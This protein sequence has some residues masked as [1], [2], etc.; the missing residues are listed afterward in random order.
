VAQIAR[1]ITPPILK[2]PPDEPAVLGVALNE[3]FVPIL[4]SSSRK[5]SI[6]ICRRKGVHIALPS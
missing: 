5:S 3:V 4:Q 2:R 1:F 6:F